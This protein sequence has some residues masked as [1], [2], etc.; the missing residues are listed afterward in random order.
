MPTFTA[1]RLTPSNTVFPLT[2]TL[3]NGHLRCRKYYLSRHYI[4]KK[5]EY[6]IAYENIAS[7]RV[8]EWCIPLVVGFFAN[9]EI[10]TT[11]RR[12]LLL[13]GFTR[14]DAREIARH[15]ANRTP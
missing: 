8:D 9:I 14:D 12:I 13:N 4:L 1:S 6:D 3:E 7:V 5:D 10:E 15:L 11:G 2:V